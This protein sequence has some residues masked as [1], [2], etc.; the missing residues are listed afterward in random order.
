MNNPYWKRK[1][2]GILHLLLKNVMEVMP[3]CKCKILSHFSKVSKL[4]HTIKEYMQ[5][6]PPSYP[7]VSI[8]V[9]PCDL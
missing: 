8:Y 5:E 4:F 3:T 7:L 1:K 2:R 9:K 6:H